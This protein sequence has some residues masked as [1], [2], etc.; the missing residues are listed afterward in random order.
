VEAR[1][2]TLRPDR[3]WGSPS[4]QYNGYRVITRG[5]ERVELYLYSPLWAFIASSK[6]TFILLLYKDPVNSSKYCTKARQERIWVSVCKWKNLNLWKC[7][8]VDLKGQHLSRRPVLDYKPRPPDYE[9]AVPCLNCNVTDY[10]AT[11]VKF[12]QQ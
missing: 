2:S 10:E 12:L 3:P 7:T 5:K 1:F 11:V 4:F 6:L 8:V 9:A